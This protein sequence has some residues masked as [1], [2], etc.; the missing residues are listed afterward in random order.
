MDDI[1]ENMFCQEK[2]QCLD[3]FYILRKNIILKPTNFIEKK[4]K[5]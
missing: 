2:I 4:Y 3:F 5:Y 1:G